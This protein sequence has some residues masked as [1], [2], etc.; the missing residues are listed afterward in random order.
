MGGIAQ[1]GPVFGIE[2]DEKSNCSAQ[3]GCVVLKARIHS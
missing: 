2:F 1:T 3:N